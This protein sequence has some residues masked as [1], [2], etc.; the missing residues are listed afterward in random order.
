[1]PPSF[2]AVRPTHD[3]ALLGPVRLGLVTGIAAEA[4]IA[5]GCCSLIGCSGGSPARARAEAER[6]VAEGATHL[7]SF[8]IAGGLDMAL[9]PGALIVP[10]AVL[11]SG[12]RRYPT[13]RIW[14]ERLL[15]ALPH[16]SC[17]PLYGSDSLI[18]SIAE[19]RALYLETGARA[20]DLESH[21]VA[22][23]AERLG[24]PFIAF[25]AVS[26]PAER[27]LPRAVRVGLKADG[28]TAIGPV[29]LDLARRPGQLALLIRTAFDAGTA[30]KSLRGLI[31]ILA[32]TAPTA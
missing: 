20:V 25:R 17:G 9:E 32:K 14:R 16:A 13:D 1:M 4:R 23:A 5:A 29:L 15:A 19:K 10:D 30:L 8:G 6:L 27:R 22:A 7:V 21:A 3:P 12:M 2:A 28:S 11:A 26:D 24:R 18:E 31:E